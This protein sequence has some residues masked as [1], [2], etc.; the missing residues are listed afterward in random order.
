MSPMAY[1]LSIGS[2]HQAIQVGELHKTETIFKKKKSDRPFK[3]FLMLFAP[4][5]LSEYFIRQIL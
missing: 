5:R 4:P 1:T 3:G 2:L